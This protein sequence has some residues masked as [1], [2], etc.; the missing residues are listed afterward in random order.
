MKEHEGDIRGYNW[1]NKSWYATAV[2]LGSDYVDEINIG[3]YCP[4]GGTSGEFSIR[5]YV[6]GD[7]KPPSA[8]I[9]CFEDA[10]HALYECKDLLKILADKDG[11]NIQPEQ[12]KELLDNLGFKD[13]TSYKEEIQ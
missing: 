5:W 10:F 9:E 12:L 8:C 2:L 11:E 7:E 4:D 3:F 13:L 6:L 1:L